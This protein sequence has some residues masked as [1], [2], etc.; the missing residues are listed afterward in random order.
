VADAANKLGKGTSLAGV[1]AVPE[2]LGGKDGDIV[3]SETWI[4]KVVTGNNALRGLDVTGLVV[5]GILH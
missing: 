4:I 1:K 2:R 3:G 5:G